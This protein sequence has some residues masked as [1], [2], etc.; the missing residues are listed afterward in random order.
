MQI[1]GFNHLWSTLNQRPHLYQWQPANTVDMVGPGIQTQDL[2]DE[3]QCLTA[4]SYPDNRCY[5]HLIRFKNN[6]FK[7]FI[8]MVTFYC[9]ISKDI[10]GVIMWVKVTQFLWN[11]VQTCETFFNWISFILPW[12]LGWVNFSNQGT[13]QICVA[14]W[15]FSMKFKILALYLQNSGGD[16]GLKDS[17]NFFGN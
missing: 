16:K 7:W 5:W 15:C 4:L 11:Y 12:T 6:T 10:D 13:T 17:K 9:F 1:A 8:S 3:N 14:I 2:S